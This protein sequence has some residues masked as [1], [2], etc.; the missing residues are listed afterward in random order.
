MSNLVPFE[1]AQ[2]PAYLTARSK[3]DLSEVMS[4][5]V[6]FP[7]ISIKGKVFHIKRGDA[8]EL[9]TKPEAPDE[10]AAGIEVLILRAGPPGKT[11]KT[12]Y[13]TGYTEGSDAKP[14]C[15]SNDGV[16]PAADAEAPQAGTCATCPHNVWGSKITEQGNKTRAC[17]DVKRL[18]VAP[19]GCVDDA[20]LLRVPAASLKALN[21]YVD[22]LAKRGVDAT[23]KVVT[24]IGFDYSVAH[25]ALT[26]K[27]VGFVDEATFHAAEAA[28]ESDVVRQIIGEIAILCDVPRTATVTANQHTVTLKINKETFFRLVTEFPQ[29]S[30]EIMRELARRLDKTNEQLRQAVAKAGG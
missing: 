1:S 18:A 15:Y 12:F 25:P 23:Y 28:R 16:G 6:S 3:Q 11:A 19:A 27:P 14:T 24:K 26:F 9:V 20:M 21:Q 8:L 29:M 4:G 13:S 17:A 10:P 7:V 30:V 5:G 2:L 22:L